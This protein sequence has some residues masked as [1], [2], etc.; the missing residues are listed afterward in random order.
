MLPYLIKKY[1]I[2]YTYSSLLF[3]NNIKNSTLNVKNRNGL[4]MAPVDFNYNNFL[5]PSLPGTEEECESISMKLKKQSINVDLL[6][7]DE[8][9]ESTF[10][11]AKNKKYA[12]IHLATHGLINENQPALSRLYFGSGTEDG[13]LYTSEIYNLKLESDLVTLSAC[14]TGLGKLSKGEGVL[15]F[16]R[17]LLSAGANNIVVSLWR[18]SD[19]STTDFMIDFYDQMLQSNKYGQSLQLAK[20]NMIHNSL[21]AEPYYWA[22]FL[23]LGR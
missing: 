21:Y 9:M 22:P 19:T 11:E 4:L 13:R 1:N 10:K 17:A 3:L 7:N 12:F 6:L 8:A 16:T 20:Q 15:G 14:E 2:S 18:V 23:L 5:L